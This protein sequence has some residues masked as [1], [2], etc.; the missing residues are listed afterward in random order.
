MDMVKLAFQFLGQIGYL[1][2]VG[3]SFPKFPRMIWEIHELIEGSQDKDNDNKGKVEENWPRDSLQMPS[4]DSMIKSELVREASKDPTNRSHHHISSSQRS[5][6]DD[7]LFAI[8]E[9]K[10]PK[11]DSEDN[12][13]EDEGPYWVD[14]EDLAEESIGQYSKHEAKN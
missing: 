7:D 6:H 1:S 3:V 5:W 13:E 9:G 11:G 2:W 8:A 14:W 4:F 12:Y 10:H